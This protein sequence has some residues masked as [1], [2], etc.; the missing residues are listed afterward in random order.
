MG[1]PLKEMRL[2]LDNRVRGAAAARP[3]MHVGPLTGRAVGEKEEKETG[4]AE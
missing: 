4:D 2:L 3:L 1:H